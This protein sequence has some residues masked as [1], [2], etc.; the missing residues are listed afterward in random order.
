[1]NNLCE[2]DLKEPCSADNQALHVNVKSF[3]ILKAITDTNFFSKVDLSPTARLIMFSLAN[4]YN[5]KITYV[6][7]SGYKLGLYAFD[8]ML[9]CLLDN[10]S[11]K[12]V[13]VEPLLVKGKSL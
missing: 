10:S 5:P 4:M 7:T 1:M 9:A 3:N 8:R 2:A 6:E 11:V 13:C 12:E